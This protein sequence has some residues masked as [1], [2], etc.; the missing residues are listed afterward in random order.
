METRNILARRMTVLWLIRLT[1]GAMALLLLLL[2]LGQVI[3]AAWTLAIG[4]ILALALILVGSWIPLYY[5]RLRIMGQGERIQICR[6][7]LY[8]ETVAVDLTRIRSVR[9]VTTPLMRWMGL[10][11]IHVGLAGGQVIFPYLSR[12][13]SQLHLPGVDI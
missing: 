11:Q 6:G 2:E 7:V 9:L 8:R 5:R 4:L 12:S 3:G 13:V 1:V 10:V